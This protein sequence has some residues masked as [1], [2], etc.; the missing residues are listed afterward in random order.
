MDQIFRLLRVRKKVYR[1]VPKLAHIY[2]NHLYFSAVCSTR[3]I[4]KLKTGDRDN[5]ESVNKKPAQES[6][7]NIDCMLAFYSCIV[8]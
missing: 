8:L 7:N 3:L 6:D 4:L 1:I 5:R 2:F